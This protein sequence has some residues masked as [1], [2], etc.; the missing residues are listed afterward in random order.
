MPIISIRDL[1]VEYGGRRVLNGV[2]LEIEHG[3]TIVA[4]DHRTGT[5]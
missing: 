2:N 3:E 4:P 1:V 5:P